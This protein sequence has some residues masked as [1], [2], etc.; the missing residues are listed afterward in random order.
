MIRP[1]KDINLPGLFLIYAGTSVST[2]F[3]TTQSFFDGRCYLIVVRTTPDKKTISLQ[4]SCI[5]CQ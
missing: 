1:G 3:N 5:P 4:P 2:M